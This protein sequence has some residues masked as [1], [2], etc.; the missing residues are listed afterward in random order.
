MASV[1]SALRTAITAANITNITTKVYRN[2]APDS[3]TYPFVT[4][5]D[6]VAR[7]PA[8]FGDGGV[9]ARARTIS[10]D[11]WQLLDAEDTT[12]VES[13][14]AAVDGADLTGADKTI[15]GCTVEDVQRL[16]LPDE[17]ICQHSLTVNVHHS[18]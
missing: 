7:V 3:E 5:D 2:I 17:N 9:L 4:F 11:L 15:F 13:L 10:V 6:D 12:L 16:I 18:N 8:L 14:L 1:A